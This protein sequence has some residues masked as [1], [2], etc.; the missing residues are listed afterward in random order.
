MPTPNIPHVQTANTFDFW[1]IQTN[2][3]INVANELR[4]TTYEKEAGLLYLSNTVIGTAFQVSGNARVDNTLTVGTL[5]ATTANI[6]G[7]LTTSNATVTGTLTAARA[8]I[9]GNLS[10]GNVSVSGALSVGGTNIATAI[11]D[12]ANTVTVSLNGLS[13]IHI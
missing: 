4:S 12:A 8:N 10:A 1:R 13:L 2:N 7:N 3:L 11:A 5:L 9:T 6:S